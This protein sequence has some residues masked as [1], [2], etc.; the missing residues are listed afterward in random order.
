MNEFFIGDPDYQQLHWEHQNLPD[1]CAIVAQSSILS[2]F[3]IDVTMDEAT[4]VAAA[5]GWYVPGI[6]TSPNDLGS[7]LEAYGV[8]THSVEDASIEQMASELQQGH[9]VLVGVNSDELWDQGP[10]AEFWNWFKEAFGFDNSSFSPADHAVAVTGID[11]SDI[12][13]PQVILNDP[14]HPDGAGQPYP[15]DRFM[16]AWENSD[17]HYTSTSIAPT[18]T[19]PLEFDIAQFLGWGTSVAGVAF[20]LDPITANAAGDL[21]N[22][23][24]SSTDW[25]AVLASI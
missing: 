19:G 8:P 16:D 7:V 5:N 11:L 3:G 12:N 14:G 24:V 1:N 6:G 20:G 15:L 23:L 17:F 18:G 10:M 2:Q 25:D 4:Y 21:V 22:S 13:N 9:R